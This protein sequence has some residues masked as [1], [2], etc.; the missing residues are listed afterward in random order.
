MLSLE[1]GRGEA[2]VEGLQS[3]ALRD[4]LAHAL[5]A[6]GEDEQELLVL[7]QVAHV[8]AAVL[9]EQVRG[10]LLLELD[11][12]VH[13]ELGEAVG[14]RGGGLVV[15]EVAA[16]VSF[17]ISDGAAYITRQVISVNGGIA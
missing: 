2:D 12:L 17:L 15:E 4:R 10:D 8:V 13:D 7:E 9:A 1:G 3:V 6:F 11:P 16:T 5:H 14:G